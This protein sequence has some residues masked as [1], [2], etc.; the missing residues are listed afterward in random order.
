MTRIRLI[1]NILIEIGKTKTARNNYDYKRHKNIDQH[2][3]RES[4]PDDRALSTTD[5]H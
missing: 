2:G 4:C 3:S 5:R 1:Q